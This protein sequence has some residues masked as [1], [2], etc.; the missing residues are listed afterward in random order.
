[1]Y[2]V[3]S[4]H[5]IIPTSLI[6]RDEKKKFAVCIVVD[7]IDWKTSVYYESEETYTTLYGYQLGSI[8]YRLRVQV[9]TIRATLYIVCL[10]CI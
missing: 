10:H 2:H 9:S 6:I 1:M 4:S 3:V 5:S 7:R 8:G